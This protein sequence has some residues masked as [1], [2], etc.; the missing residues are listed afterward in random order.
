MVFRCVLS[1]VVAV[2]F[3]FLVTSGAAMTLG[4][5]QNITD[6]EGL[7]TQRQI[8][9]IS[10]AIIDSDVNIHVRTLG[11]S[12][13]W[14]T[15]KTPGEIMIVLSMSDNEARVS[16]LSTTQD[17][18][19]ANA[20]ESQM[21]KERPYEGVI[22]SVSMI[23]GYVTGNGDVDDSA[24]QMSTY[25]IPILVVVPVASLMVFLEKRR[26]RSWNRDTDKVGR[27][28]AF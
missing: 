27:K 11:I 22:D 16:G 21:S 1:L 18:A 14:P 13:D 12:D 17:K 2:M 20:I 23:H 15:T 24:S 10:N 19:V 26:K 3:G 7:F 8:E 6:D 5:T 25:A 4:S 9:S 28:G